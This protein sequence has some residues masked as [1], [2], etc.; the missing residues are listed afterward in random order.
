[1]LTAWAGFSL[2]KRV[3]EISKLGFN[4]K[5]QTLSLFYRWNKVRYVVCKYQYQQARKQPKS[6]LQAFSIELA[7][8]TEADENIVYFDETTAKCG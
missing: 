4:V 5:P 3:H 2:V 1:M 7:K 8:R 6:L